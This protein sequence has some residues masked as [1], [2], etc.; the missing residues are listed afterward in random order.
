MKKFFLIVSAAAALLLPVACRKDKTPADPGIPKGAIDLGLKVYWAECNL[1]A[2]SP[3]DYGDF[4]AWGEI[5]PYYTEGHS[6][7][8][9]CTNWRERSDHPITGY[10]WASY[11]WC[12]GTYSTLTKYN[13]DEVRGTVDGKLSLKDYDY[14][15][16]AARA[17]LDKPWRMPT[18]E[19]FEELIANCSAEW[20]TLN[21]VYGCKFTSNV[22]GYKEK[23]IFFPAAGS[24]EDDQLGAEGVFGYY[25]SS[26]LDEDNPLGPWYLYFDHG[27]VSVSSPG[28]GRTMG[29]PIRPVAE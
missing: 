4:Y 22:E 27:T 28:N 23:W 24:R 6:Q 10:N 11:L 12:N 5:I 25:W 19:D 29:I 21:G 2:S 3:E 18:D 15:D 16:D 8:S 17:A 9:P 20:I 26:V 7:D 1:G 14:E 13:N